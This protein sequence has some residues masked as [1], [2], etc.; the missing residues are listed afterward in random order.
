MG[1]S[2]FAFKE[3]EIGYVFGS[4][5]E[6]EEFEDIDVALPISKKFSPYRR[7][8]FAMRVGREME[9]NI[10]SRY[11]IDVKILNNSLLSFQYQ[12]IKNGK[13]IFI[14]NER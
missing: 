5:L 14:R 11:E 13:P 12:V 6:R 4:F 8:K 3:I 7:G 9:K 1:D 2:L 10:Q